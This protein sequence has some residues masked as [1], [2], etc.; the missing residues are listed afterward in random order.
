MRRIERIDALAKLG[1]QLE[2]E[3]EYLEALMRRAQFH[4]PWF[5]I[6]NQRLALNAIA[7]AYLRQD[8]LEGWLAAY[9]DHE[10]DKPLTIGLIMAGNIPL[11]GMHD[12]LCVFLAG[13]RALIKLS[14]K[15]PYLPPYLLK[16]LARI[17]PRAAEC[18][19]TAERLSGFDAVIA[20]GSDN[21]ARYFHAYFGKYPHIIR[22]NRNGVA[23]LDGRETRE[24]LSA[25]GK[26]VFQYFGLG[27]RNVSKLYVP[28]GYDF[29]SLLEAL[30]EY[31]EI[32]LHEK[33]KNNFDYNYALCALNKQA[34][35]A[36]SC[37]ILMESADPR[38][39]IGMLHY[40]YYE[41]PT[42]LERAL[43]QRQSEIQCVVA[44][45]PW[46]PLPTY[47]F[48]QAQSPGLG[49]YADGVDT[50][51]FLTGLMGKKQA[52]AKGS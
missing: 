14:D 36:N 16:L 41:D 3:D 25:L 44:G 45:R 23:V 51:A 12:L 24:Q 21:S 31:R 30:H 48:G 39:R 5:T 15:D 22:G 27:C 38:S 52:A 20:T 7:T 19:Q 17:E 40:E 10:P 11:V 9:P 4:N 42:T 33:Y 34:H 18:F 26:D 43:L 2:G 32:I 50:M 28:K 29:H 46:P 47:P 49:D 35:M 13:H 8:K 1:R 6:E 37:I